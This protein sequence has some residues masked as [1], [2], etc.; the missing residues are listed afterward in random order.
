MTGLV[1]KKNL[2]KVRARASQNLMFLQLALKLS[3]RSVGKEK[4]K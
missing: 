2:A 4:K 3:V 1:K